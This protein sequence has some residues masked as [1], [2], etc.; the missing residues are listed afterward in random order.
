M[1]RPR[2]PARSESGAT[3][4]GAYH[5]RRSSLARARRRR[6]S[7]RR[8]GR[9]L[10]VKM[11]TTAGQP[12]H[13]PLLVNV[14][15]QFSRVV[16]SCSFYANRS[17]NSDKI[18]RPWRYTRHR[19]RATPFK[20][21]KLLDLTSI[22]SL[23]ISVRVLRFLDHGS[24]HT[25][26]AFRRTSGASLGERLDRLPS[27]HTGRRAH[28]APAR[29]VRHINNACL[30]RAAAQAPLYSGRNQNTPPGNAPSPSTEHAVNARESQGSYASMIQE[31]AVDQY[32]SQSA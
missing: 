20:R 13:W 11:R 6:T 15:S 29:Q 18:K 28:H 4:E 31:A 12:H 22:C 21:L 23:L 32:R 10:C 8:G 16:L 5:R 30:L 26:I 27:P 7:P 17:L 3:A 9:S 2:P 19:G 25:P 1:K 24:P 14:A